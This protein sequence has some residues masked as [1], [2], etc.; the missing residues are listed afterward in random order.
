MINL[1]DNNLCDDQS[2]LITTFDNLLFVFVMI[3]LFGTADRFFFKNENYFCGA[4]NSVFS[5]ACS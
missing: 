3:N 2:V 4:C 1:F 5:G